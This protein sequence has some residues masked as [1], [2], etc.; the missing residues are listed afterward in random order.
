MPQAER[1]LFEKPLEF[2]KWYPSLN[3]RYT[4]YG[5][6]Y[7]RPLASPTQIDRTLNDQ[8]IFDWEGYSIRCLSLPGHSPGSMTYVIEINGQ[9]LA[10]S[11]DLM[12]DGAKLVT[13][14]DSE[15]DYG[16][17]SGLDTLMASVDLAI[18][19][20]FDLLLPSHGPLVREPKQ[21]QQYAGKLGRFREH[22]VRGYPVFDMTNEERDSL[23]KPTAV[24]HLNQVSPHLFKLRD[25]TKGQNF[26]MIIADSGHALVLDCGLLPEAMLD[27]IIVGAR[28]HLCLKKIDAFWVSH[29]HGDH[30]LLGPVMQQKYGAA[31][32]TLDRVVDRCEHPRRYDYAALVSAYADGFDGMKID[33]SIKD[34]EVIEWEGFK[35][36]VD[37]MP[38]QNRVWLLLVAGNRRQ[39]CGVYRRQFIRKSSRHKT[40]WT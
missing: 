5:A 32:W 19:Q 25:A 1:D 30:F 21:L 17:A 33:R 40:K 37:W 10:F 39:A 28:T 22:Y 26:A 16:F 34:G 9:K 31:S 23:S 4:V 7:V 8:E 3:D 20:H 11:G 6:S 12:H 14:F 2:R 13:W 35:I 38:G 29:M 36:Q 18:K 27:E 24:P 15:W